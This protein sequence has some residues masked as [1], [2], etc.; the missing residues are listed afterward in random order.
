MKILKLLMN[1][2][3][4]CRA[5]DFAYTNV[6]RP[7]GVCSVDGTA[8]TW[9]PIV[10]QSSFREPKTYFNLR[11]IIFYLVESCIMTLSFYTFQ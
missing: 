2:K 8:K 1:E 11:V 6:G 5:V 4:N 7:L 3:K 10:N 9:P